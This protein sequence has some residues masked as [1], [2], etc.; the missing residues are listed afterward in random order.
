MLDSDA[1]T[2]IAECHGRVGQ[3]WNGNSTG[4]GLPANDG[5]GLC[6][7]LDVA[8]STANVL[9]ISS[10]SFR[11]RWKLTIGEVAILCGSWSDNRQTFA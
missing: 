1:A 5:L 2:L 7:G 11:L 3:Q 6:A 10:R 4:L 8:Q 9:D